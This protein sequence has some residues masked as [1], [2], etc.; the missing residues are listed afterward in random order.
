M[1]DQFILDGINCVPWSFDK[2][3]EVLNV[4]TGK[5]R[6]YDEIKSHHYII[7]FDPKDRDERGL[8]LEHAQELGMEFASLYSA[9]GRKVTVIEAMSRILPTLDKEISQSLKM[10]MK[11]RGV[12]IHTDARVMEIRA[13]HSCGT[14][15]GL[16]QGISEPGSDSPRN[17]PG[18]PGSLRTF[19]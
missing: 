11:K 13:D 18:N 4:E 9:L 3:C 7:S 12:E 8:T 1:R 17:G 19:S 5:N 6:K 14:R 10:L 16:L 15:S 2:E